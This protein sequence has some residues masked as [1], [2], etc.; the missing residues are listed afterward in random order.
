MPEP[1]L[2]ALIA[3]DETACRETLLHYLQKYCPQVECI[4]EAA[5]VPSTV[6]Q[7]RTLKPD[8]V[9]LDVEMPYG[10]AFDV[11]EQTAG[12]PFQTIFVTAFSEYA[13]RALNSSA[14]YYLLKP[15]NINQLIKAVEKVQQTPQGKDKLGVLREN[16]GPAG[17]KKLLIPTLQGAEVLR[18]DEVL[19]FSGNG[20]YTDIYLRDGKK[21]TVSRVL[22]YFD[23][24]LE[25]HGFMRV[26][27]SHLVRIDAVSAWHR[28]KGGYAVL[29]DGSEIEVSPSKKDLLL[30]RLGQQS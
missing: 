9:F 4:G 13:L 16:L 29:E 20:N 7:I 28:G 17:L 14:A 27:K 2:K 3:D 22:R 26:H 10:N 8:L 23:E 25:G 11:L 18:L 12:I 19:R 24:L 5:D 1:R 21:K 15:L 30:E 6:A